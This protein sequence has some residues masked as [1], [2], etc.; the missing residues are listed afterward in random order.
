MAAKPKIALTCAQCNKTA[1]CAVY[2][3]DTSPAC[4]SFA[5]SVQ[6]LRDD[7]FLQQINALAGH[8]SFTLDPSLGDELR[9]Y[10]TSTDSEFKTRIPTR[11]EGRDAFVTLSSLMA[12]NQAYRDRVTIIRAH[13]GQLYSALSRNFSRGMAHAL[14]THGPIMASVSTVDAR[15]SLVEMYALP[16]LADRIEQLAGVRDLADLIK[17]NLKNTHFT[18]QDVFNSL[19]ESFFVAYDPKPPRQSG[20]A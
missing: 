14:H 12:E 4:P 9:M 2:T 11:H 20:W 16:D 15:R 10:H 18:L 5:I 8:P 7:P 3:D 1:S 6:P 13:L 19:R 17:D